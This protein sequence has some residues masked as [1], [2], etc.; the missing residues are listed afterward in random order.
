MPSR[1]VVGS[2]GQALSHP[3]PYFGL[4]AAPALSGCATVDFYAQSVI[5]HLGLMARA[6]PVEIVIAAPETAPGLAARL[7]TALEIREFASDALALPANA[8][9]RR[10]VDL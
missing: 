7:R 1:R 2:T 10:Y 6:R 5:G 4:C 3:N 9:Y 8:S